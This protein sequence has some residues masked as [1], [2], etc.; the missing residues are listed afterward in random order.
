MKVELG[1]GGA[2]RGRRRRLSPE[3]QRLWSR[4]AASTDALHPEDSGSDAPNSEDRARLAQTR[5][6]GSNGSEARIRLAGSADSDTAPRLHAKSLRAKPLHAKPPRAKPSRANGIQPRIGG[7][8]L[9]DARADAR[10]EELHR[11]TANGHPHSPQTAGAALAQIIRTSPDAAPVGRREPGLDRRTAE[12]LRKGA[13]EP[14]ARID[15][16]G[17]TAERAHNA[18]LRFVAAGLARQD[19]VLLVVTGKGKRCVHGH[20]TA[21]GVLRQSLPGW[22]RASP[23]GSSVIGIYQAHQRHGGAGAFYIYLKRSR[24]GRR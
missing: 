18:C 17:M 5:P 8:S 19:R 22:L 2:R 4:V 7:K 1:M 9:P 20:F 11:P 13:R 24:S 23:L 15:L 16:H 21:R 14:D 6:N 3:E 10:P 12:R